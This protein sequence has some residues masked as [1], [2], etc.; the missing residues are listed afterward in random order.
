[1]CACSKIITSE[2]PF[3]ALQKQNPTY[4]ECGFFQTLFNKF[5]FGS[6]LSHNLCF[7]SFV[8]VADKIIIDVS[9]VGKYMT[10]ACNLV[11]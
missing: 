1:M 9:R 5:S 2:T 7:L 8:F 10:T 3:F 4:F 11:S 6:I